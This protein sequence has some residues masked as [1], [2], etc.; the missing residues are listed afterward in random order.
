MNELIEKARNGDKN[1]FSEIYNGNRS[2]LYK[3]CRNLCGDSH[4]TDDLMQ[5]TYLRA[6]Q[7]ISEI[8]SE[9]VSSWLRTIARNIFLNN[10]RKSK[11][12]YFSEELPEIPDNSANPEFVA[13][14]RDICRIL[15]KALKD[16]LSP[17]QRATVIFYYYDEKS[18]SEIADIMKCSKGTV[19]SRL[20]SAR[21]KLRE[22]LKKFGNIFTC[23]SL[24][25]ATVKYKLKNIQ[26]PI[27][28]RISASA[29]LTVTA[30]T[31]VSMTN[32]SYDGKLPDTVITINETNTSFPETTG[33][34]ILKSSETAFINRLRGTTT[35][36]VYY[37]TATEKPSNLPFKSKYEDFQDIIEELTE[38]EPQEEGDTPEETQ[39]TT[40]ETITEY[41]EETTMKK[42]IIS[43]VTALTTAFSGMT[44]M[45]TTAVD[46]TETTTNTTEV[47]YWVNYP[48]LWYQYFDGCEVVTSNTDKTIYNHHIETIKSLENYYNSEYDI[49]APKVNDLIEEAEPYILPQESLKVEDMWRIDFP[50]GLTRF[51]T[52]ERVRDCLRLKIDVRCLT[53]E[54]EENA[55]GG[56]KI[57]DDIYSSIMEDFK[58]T[59]LSE[60][61]DNYVVDYGLRHG[62][63]TPDF[64][65][66][67]GWG[68]GGWI[69]FTL[70]SADSHENYRIAREIT[71]KLVDKYGF[72]AVSSDLW[73]DCHAIRQ[74]SFSADEDFENKGF[75]AIDSHYLEKAN[76]GAPAPFTKIDVTRG[77]AYFDVAGLAE[78]LDLQPI[79]EN[80][81]ILSENVQIAEDSPVSVSLLGDVNLDGR[82]SISD[83][84]AI[85]QYLANSEKYP[86]SPQAMANADIYNTGDGITGG[87]ASYIQ[88]LEATKS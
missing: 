86:L 19:E 73:L 61:S 74:F 63:G 15:L 80:N 77:F 87:D 88:Q 5:Q 41:E 8:K 1:A 14:K 7:K 16:S 68:D 82:V 12:E 37:T 65:H 22:E 48:V 78:S 70:K 17:V 76:Y 43:A 81:L 79:S 53:D 20:F 3:Y 35:S 85:I 21:K 33:E 32:I 39:P 62:Y 71:Q 18:V 83:S 30:M 2:S 60:I 56:L 45:M 47:P 55:L 51:Y 31:A 64:S 29:V 6:W 67:Y 11:P 44:A 13:E 26:I 57:P 49:Y 50:T 72:E 42:E 28:A 58:S 54:R 23:L 4:D 25:T 38:E 59:V 9:N 66:I 46:E 40:T 75:A 69:S 24:A 34:K 84:V 10:L 52:K 27:N 36:S